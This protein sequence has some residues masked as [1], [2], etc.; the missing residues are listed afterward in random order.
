M[1]K[2]TNYILDLK[3]KFIMR[4]LLF[5][6]FSIIISYGCDIDS[7][8]LILVNH[9]YDT[10]YY[11]L[12]VDTFLEKKEYLYDLAPFDSVCPLFVRGSKGAWDYKIN[13]DSKDSTLHIY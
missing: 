7:K 12:Q 10:I 11:E 13:K 1:K 3:N 8:E 6:L 9:G 2:K 5:L 4:N